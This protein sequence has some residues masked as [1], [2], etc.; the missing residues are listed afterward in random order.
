MN[1]NEESERN[2]FVWPVILKN[3]N[4]HANVDFYYG[5]YDS[6]DGLKEGVPNDLWVPGFTAAVQ[7]ADGTV[8]EWW[9]QG[10]GAA[11]HWEQKGVRHDTYIALKGVKQSLA[12]VE[13]IESPEVGDMYLV[14]EDDGEGGFLEYVHTGEKWELL[15]RNSGK[16]K[17]TLTVAH[18]GG[19]KDSFDGTEDV[20]VDLSG[21][22]KNADLS[23][24]VKKSELT[25][26]DLNI[27]YMHLSEGYS[28]YFDKDGVKQYSG[29]RKK[30]HTG[31]D[32]WSD[33]TKTA[34]EIG[35]AENYNTLR[36]TDKGAY[37]RY[38]DWARW[39]LNPLVL[40]VMVTS[41]SSGFSIYYMYD[42]YYVQKSFSLKMESSYYTVTHK[43]TTNGVTK[44][45]GNYVMTG[46]GFASGNGDGSIFVTVQEY[47]DDTL[48]F[49]V[50][51][52]RSRDEFTRCELFFY[53][54]TK[55]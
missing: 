36:I 4:A 12:E 42:P 23:G 35:T 1:K 11:A 38:G 15:G 25:A 7:D 8:T 16:T 9:V 34:V 55:Y 10:E 45:A 13:A 52:D 20:T 44:G 5:P 30:T 31:S 28:Y 53:D 43:L 50:A 40:A 32:T 19:G 37:Y 33:G 39:R 51:N 54:F 49:I 21:Y 48:K 6:L 18:S 22:V 24:Y 29:F 47:N 14:P 41:G 27:M 3:P 46:S 2:G 17:G 26:Q